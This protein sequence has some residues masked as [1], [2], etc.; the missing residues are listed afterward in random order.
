MADA[1]SQAINAGR[2]AYEA[3]V[4]PKRDIAKPSTPTH[5]QPIWQQYD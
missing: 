3:G 5:D 4:M 2:L 1:F